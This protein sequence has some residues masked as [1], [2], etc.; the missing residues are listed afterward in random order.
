MPPSSAW[1][2]QTHR[3]HLNWA[4]PQGEQLSDGA[5]SVVLLAGG[6]GKRMG[7]RTPTPEWQALPRPAVHGATCTHCLSLAVRTWGGEQ[8]ANA[9]ACEHEAGSVRS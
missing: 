5:V 8:A 4:Y 6:V 2:F 7:V 1:C 9:N 3:G